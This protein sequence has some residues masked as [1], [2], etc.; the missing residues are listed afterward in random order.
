MSLRRLKVNH[1]KELNS[2]QED[3]SVIFVSW[4]EIES[5]LISTSATLIP[6]P[7]VYF[8]QHDWL[9]LSSY[10]FKSQNSARITSGAS[11]ATTH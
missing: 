8:L 9:A 4:R 5:I 2:S 7:V 1:I 10:T 3:S 6:A 11:A